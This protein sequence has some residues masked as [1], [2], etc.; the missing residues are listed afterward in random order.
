M[1][2]E[3]SGPVLHAPVIVEENGFRRPLNNQG[4]QT[5]LGDTKDDDITA[6]GKAFM[7]ND[8]PNELIELQKIVLESSMFG[9]HRWA[10]IL[11]VPLDFAIFSHET[12]AF[13][14]GSSECTT[15]PINSIVHDQNL[16][17]R[18]NGHSFCCRA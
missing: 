18:A 9:N 3:Y 12:Q 16:C 7:T 13:L 5:A 14:I 4:V 17:Y 10:G 2:S 8:M 15:E 11:S 6:T 1:P